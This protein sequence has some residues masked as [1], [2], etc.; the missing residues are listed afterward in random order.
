MDSVDSADSIISPGGTGSSQLRLPPDVM[1]NHDLNHRDAHPS[2]HQTRRSRGNREEDLD[3]DRK[4]NKDKAKDKCVSSPRS[5]SRSISKRLERSLSL[6]FSHNTPDPT[7]S[8]SGPASGTVTTTSLDHVV[9]HPSRSRSRNRLQK[10]ASTHTLKTSTSTPAMTHGQTLDHQGLTALPQLSEQAIPQRSSSLRKKPRPLTA[11]RPLSSKDYQ[12][13]VQHDRRIASAPNGILSIRPR[14][15]TSEVAPQRDYSLHEEASSPSSPSAS[16]SFSSTSPPQATAT[17]STTSQRTRRYLPLAPNDPSPLNPLYHI[18]SPGTPNKTNTTA[19][20]MDPT[21][22]NSPSGSSTSRR[23]EHFVLPP[24]FKPGKTEHTHV[25]EV[26]HP[27]VTREV[28]K[29]KR[30]EIVHEEIT[31]HI[32]VHHYYTYV[33]PIRAVEVLPARH[34]VIDEKTGQKVEI[35]APEGWTMPTSLQPTTPDLTGLGPVSRHYL[36]DEEHPNGI[37]EPPPPD[38]QEKSPQELKS[39]ARATHA[40]KWSP[41]PKIR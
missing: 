11:D 21:Y 4:T 40:A 5:R 36:V 7:R 1:R 30:T 20:S 10:R 35:P 23:S 19:M 41:F 2:S 6:S 3:T 25:E 33:Q 34:F 37:P 39:I 12:E 16:A 15:A 9:A 26:I 38:D 24:G 8:H 28:V 29:N 14:P 17:T 27:T 13:P 32:H 18:P 31:R 22:N